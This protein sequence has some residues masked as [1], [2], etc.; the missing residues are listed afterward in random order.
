MLMNYAPYI[1]NDVS[2][3][4]NMVEKNILQNGDHVT[5]VTLNGRFD[6]SKLGKKTSTLK[7]YEEN[8]NTNM[9]DENDY[10]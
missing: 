8:T 9:N 4:A 7:N 2:E 1:M 3:R 5:K 6:D 10:I